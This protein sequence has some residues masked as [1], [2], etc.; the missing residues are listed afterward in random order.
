MVLKMALSTGLLETPG[1][2]A[3][4][5]KVTSI[6]RS[7]VE[8]ALAEFKLDHHGLQLEKH[9]ISIPNIISLNDD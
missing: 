5:M 1:V 7:L 2:Q 4:V 6:L 8:L 9:E 3:G